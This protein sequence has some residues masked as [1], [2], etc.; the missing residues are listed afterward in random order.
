M[1]ILVAMSGGIDSSVVAHLLKQQGHEL[2]GVRFTLWS[3]PLAP[4]LAEILPSKCCNAQ[5]AARSHAVA[6]ALGIPL[7][8][9]DLQ[10]EFKTN[11]VD[12]FLDGYR[13]GLTP[14]PCIGC[15]R[16][17]KFGKLTE[18]MREL[19]C[20]RLATGHYA[21]V[22]RERLTD[23]SER[24][25]LLEAVDA[26]KDQSYYLYGL[27][28]EQLSKAL[29]P[30]GT[31]TKRDVFSLAREFGVP[32][33]EQYRESQDL[34]FFPEK[35]PERF[36][37]RHLVLEPGKIVRRDGVV[38]GTHEGLP[39][40]TIGQRRGLG[41]GGLRIPLEVVAKETATN[42]LIV[43]EKGSE[44]TREIRVKE[45]RWISWKPERA[46]A[47]FEARTRS[48][49]ARHRGILRYDGDRGTF[50]VQAPLPPQAPGQSLVLYRG[51]E[52]VGGG[53]IV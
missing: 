24:M 30:L 46:D 32:F 28:Q 40:Y 3:D 12:P 50:S 14:N 35:T 41:I 10:N 15:N 18:L 36:L 5:T 37:R 48:L 13:K 11:V 7:H 49:S 39:L 23:E 26:A 21:R 25:L 52:I 51:E 16:T 44:N 43:A 1:R 31:L 19:G 4:A 9:I 38:V 33:D 34:C 6:K 42:R 22:A 2:V 20:E 47:A 29:F 17:I 27:T 8:I 53:V 45:L